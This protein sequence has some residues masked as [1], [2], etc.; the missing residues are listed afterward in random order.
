M[1]RPEVRTGAL[2]AGRYRVGALLGGGA[3]ALVY[4][5]RHEPAGRDVAVKILRDVHAREPL[6][7]E[8]FLREARAANRIRHPNVVDVT[9]VG[10]S[11]DGTPFLVMEL[12]EGAPL[13]ARL[14][15]PWPAARVERL[16]VELARALAAG[17]ALGVVH[18][19]LTPENVLLL[20]GDRLKVVDFGL[21]RLDGERRLTASAVALGTPRY[22][23]PEQVLGGPVTDRTDVYALACILFEALTGMPPFDGAGPVVMAAHVRTPPPSIPGSA[24]RALAE[25][26]A[27]GLAKTPD[28]RPSAADILRAL[29]D[30]EAAEV[31]GSADP[32]APDRLRARRDL[33][34]RLLGHLHPDGALPPTLAR[35]L[36]DVER[37]IA[38]L[39]GEAPV[40]DADARAAIE[41]RLRAEG[42]E[43]PVDEASMRAL[44][45]L[46]ALAERWLALEGAAPDDAPPSYAEAEGVLDALEAY[47]AAHPDGAGLLPRKSR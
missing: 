11:E 45:G 19:D 29:G 16:A 12:I 7:R 15:E 14:G 26:L 9:D 5:G 20:P 34:A 33:A 25:L 46:G 22:M 42:F 2:L 18:R 3:H 23:A 38:A 13:R 30:D 27:A 31:R 35:G 43:G 47:V 39:H 36:R 44:A 28:A 10:E 40:P 37:A 8:R 21:A 17:H 32:S 41:A 6:M 24:G 4:R 1:P